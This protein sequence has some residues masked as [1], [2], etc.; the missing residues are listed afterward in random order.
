MRLSSE[1]TTADVRIRSPSEC[2]GRDWSLVRFHYASVDASSPPAASLRRRVTTYAAATV[3]HAMAPT[4]FLLSGMSGRKHAGIRIQTQTTVSPLE[5]PRETAFCPVSIRRG[6]PSRQA[7][8][9]AGPSWPGSTDASREITRVGRSQ[10]RLLRLDRPAARF[11]S[12]NA[13]ALT[14][15]SGVWLILSSTVSHTCR[16]P[17]PSVGA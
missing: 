6:P 13:F 7:P 4:C 8:V 1:C 3:I 2:V 12:K 10:R 14:A 5:T 16:R 11:L 17:V 9:C 15:R